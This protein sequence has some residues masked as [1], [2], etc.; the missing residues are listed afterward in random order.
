MHTTEEGRTMSNKNIMPLKVK[1]ITHDQLSLSNDDTEE[2]KNFIVLLAQQG[3]KDN[4]VN[5]KFQRKE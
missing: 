5:G 4:I 1:F 2:L 3:F